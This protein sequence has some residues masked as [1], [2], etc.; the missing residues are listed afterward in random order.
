MIH[1]PVLRHGVPYT[2]LDRV[3]VPHHRTREP[4]VEISQ[5]NPGLIRRDLRGEVQADA[6]P[7][8][9]LAEARAALAAA[10]K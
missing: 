1:I 5:A 7:R 9:L 2:S 4:F 3:I 8:L 10:Q 6:D